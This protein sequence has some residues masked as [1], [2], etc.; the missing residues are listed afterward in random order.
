MVKSVM[1]FSRFDATPSLTKS[2]VKRRLLLSF[3]AWYTILCGYFT[4]L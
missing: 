4:A 1:M 2:L 3:I